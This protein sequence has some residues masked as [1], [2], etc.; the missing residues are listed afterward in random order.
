MKER[1]VR[2]ETCASRI[3]LS[4]DST[5]AGGGT[6]PDLAALSVFSSSTLGLDYSLHSFI[7]FQLV[8]TVPLSIIAIIIYSQLNDHHAAK[9]MMTINL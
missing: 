6:C 1:Y 2:Q 3:H 9:R 5:L 4:W 7:W 8:R